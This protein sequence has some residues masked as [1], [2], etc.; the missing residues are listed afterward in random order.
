MSFMSRLARIGKEAKIDRILRNLNRVFN[1]RKRYGSV[2]HEFGI[3]DYE[4]TWNTP[5]LLETLRTELLYAVR[6]YEPEVFEPEIA[7]DGR[8][9][10]LWV[11]FVLTGLVDGEPQRFYIEIDSKYRNV[12]VSLP[13]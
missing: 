10:Q 9:N 13:P 3:G 5:I 11:R 2:V 7:L 4:Y 12:A 8:D 1:S 6:E